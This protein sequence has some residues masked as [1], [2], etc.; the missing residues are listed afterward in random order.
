[1]F[2]I[3]VV[4]SYLHLEAPNTGQR[5]PEQTVL[6]PR[7]DDQIS[8]LV[9][10]N[11][12]LTSQS[13]FNP[14]LG[15]RGAMGDGGHLM[16]T[17][18]LQCPAIKGGKW[19]GNP[20][21]IGG[22]N[23]NIPKTSCQHSK[24]LTGGYH[25]VNRWFPCGFLTDPQAEPTGALRETTFPLGKTSNLPGMLPCRKS[26]SGPCDWCWCSGSS[27][28]SRLMYVNVIYGLFVWFLHLLAYFID[29]WNMMTWSSVCFMIGWDDWI[30]PLVNVYITFT[31]K[32][33]GFL[34]GKSA[35]E[36]TS[37]NGKLWVYQRVHP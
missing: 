33:P 23:R 9:P 13:S 26:P 25:L 3:S 20:L 37:F 30:Y 34:S 19:L 21:K 27:Q 24:C 35:T 14:L 10:H 5:A 8:S 4:A 16:A 6:G 12:Q 22:F 31:R 29:V 28:V 7:T 17:I 36:M 11:F 32:S 2:I 18:T 1:M 15:R